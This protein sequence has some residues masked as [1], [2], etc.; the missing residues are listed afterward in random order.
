LQSVN[1]GSKAA[2]ARA[3]WAYC[4]IQTAAFDRLSF[5]AWNSTVFL[6]SDVVFRKLQQA[7]M[8]EFF[9]VVKLISTIH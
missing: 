7:T 3:Q 2:P 4:S 6:P 8:R 5:G 9:F 1:P